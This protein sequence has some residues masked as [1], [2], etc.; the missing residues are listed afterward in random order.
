MLFSTIYPLNFLLSKNILDRKLSKFY[1]NGALD[2]D[3]K[4]RCGSGNNIKKVVRERG[5]EPLRVAPLDPKSSAS[6]NS[7]TLACLILKDF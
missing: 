3:R 1:L 2:L 5:V 6:A 7:A 4:V